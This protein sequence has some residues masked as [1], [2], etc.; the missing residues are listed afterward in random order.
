MAGR[1]R[2]N[3]EGS[4]YP[5]KNGYAA[6]AWVET[7][8]G[9]K[10]RKYV[11]GK[12]REEVH[13]KWIKLQK[14]AAEGPVATSAPT[15]GAFLEYWLK[16]VI[17]PNRAPS[18]YTGYESYVRLHI[19][20]KLGTKR[21]NR[22]TARDVQKWI[23][24][25]AQI[26]QCCAQGKDAARKE[27]KR[28]CCAIGECCNQVL[29]AR[30]ISDVRTCLRS[31]LSDA[32]DEELIARN[33]AQKI[34]LPSVRKKKRVRWS[35]DQARTFLESARQDNDPLYAAYVL[36]LVLGMRKGEVLGVPVNAIDFEV[37]ELEISYQLQRIGRK[38]LHRETKTEASDSTLP[39]PSITVTA[40][41]LRLADRARDKELVPEHRAWQENG[42]VFTTRYGTPI[43]PRN[44]NRSWDRRCALAGVPRI[45][46]HGARR[47]CGS[48]LADL[49]VH[50][51]VAMAILRHAQ[52]AITMEIY[53]EVSSQ[54][55]RDALKRLSDALE[56]Q[57][58]DG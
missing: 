53:T 24:K 19:A 27:A 44:F 34:K 21:L 49:D 8:S 40:L 12:T 39:L 51:R 56:L 55:T 18:T 35:S 28:R 52:F 25:L 15:L 13:E 16:E 3:G 47:V 43:E 41:R 36:I 38:L 4:I 48:L 6:Y 45:T 1:A 32:I 42:L 20:P 46:V 9:L 26:C 31:A 23:N 58:S 54:S 37:A 7:P 22:L 10:K 29:S 33:V 5:Y 17:K 57:P 14:E 2:A 30:T 11:Y 50:P